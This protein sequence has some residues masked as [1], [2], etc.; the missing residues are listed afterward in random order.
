M[1]SIVDTSNGKKISITSL[2][3][4]MPGSDLMQYDMPT[5]YVDRRRLLYKLGIRFGAGRFR[6]QVKLSSFY[7]IYNVL[8][9]LSQLRLN[10]WAIFVPEELSDVR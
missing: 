10:Q 8:I 1:A 2:N 5:P 3:P 7:L 6:V 9:P 4:T